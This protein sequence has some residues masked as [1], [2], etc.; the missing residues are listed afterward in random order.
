MNA[1]IAH[2]VHMVLFWYIPPGYL[3][4]PTQLQYYGLPKYPSM[5][6]SCVVHGIFQETA[7]ATV[8]SKCILYF[9]MMLKG[10]CLARVS[11]SHFAQ[12]PLDQSFCSLYFCL[13]KI[14]IICPVILH[15]LVNWL[16]SRP[17]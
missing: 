4:M 12:Y 7:L 5:I 16:V 15:V 17:C 3:L 13:L 11:F 1:N 8:L 10:L 9:L 14:K 6:L 2:Q